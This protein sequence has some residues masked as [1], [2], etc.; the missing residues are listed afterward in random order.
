MK[1]LAEWEIVP[2]SQEAKREILA[3]L[4]AYN[5]PHFPVDGDLS[6]CIFDSEGKV[7]AGLI[8]WRAMGFAH[9]DVLWVREDLRRSGLGGR[10]L[11]QAESLAKKA[12]AEVLTLDTFSFQ[13]P[14]F[15][16]R[17]GYRLMG[18]ARA[19]EM[20]WYFYKKQL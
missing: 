6:L 2:A 19:G 5:R 3:G 10:L 7:A 1:K 15:Y 13:A 9:V 20:T 8:G 11:E 17:H 18:S 12:G 16:P 4:R 14:E